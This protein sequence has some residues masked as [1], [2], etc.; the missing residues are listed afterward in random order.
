M[1]FKNLEN[2]SF[3]GIAQA[4][5]NTPSEHL[6]AVLEIIETFITKQPFIKEL[7]KEEEF[8]IIFLI[9]KKFKVLKFYKE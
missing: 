5:I 7:W 4:G 3:F 1:S 9:L 2:L 8:L 6:Q